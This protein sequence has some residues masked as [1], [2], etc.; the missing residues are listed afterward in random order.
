MEYIQFSPQGA[1]SR[2]KQN[3]RNLGKCN[4]DK[5]EKLRTIGWSDF[6]I[7]S[8]N[9]FL[10]IFLTVNFPDLPPLSSFPVYDIEWS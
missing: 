1:V 10:I 7:S 2:Q 8:H 5:E 4:S 9:L 6:E 3:C